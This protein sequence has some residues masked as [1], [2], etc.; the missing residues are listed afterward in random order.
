MMAKNM[1][2]SQ[3]T[4]ELQIYPQVLVNVKVKDKAV[5]QADKDVQKFTD[6]FIKTVD[7]MVDV[8]TK[9]IMTV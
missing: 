3:L 7:N 5:V 9:D 6:E 2:M 8:K 1:K 4:E